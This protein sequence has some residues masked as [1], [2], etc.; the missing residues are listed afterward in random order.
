MTLTFPI[1]SGKLTMSVEVS[2]LVESVRTDFQQID[3][4]DSEVFGRML[5]LDG[6]I[7][8][9]TFDER[10]Y[11][12]ALVWAP[13]S[14]V[15]D[16]RSALVVGGGD[17]GVLRELCR[18]RSIERIDMVEIDQGVI[19]VCRR[20][21]P[22]LSDGAFD[23]PRVHLTVGDAFAFVKSADGPYDLI[24]VDCTDVYE[25]EEGELSEMLFTE[26]F[27][28]DV[29]RLLAPGGF[30]VTQADNMVFCP[31]SLDEIERLFS[32]VFPS[33]G[34][35]WATVPSFGG[36]SAFCWGSH[37]PKPAEQAP[38]GLPDLHYLTADIY[39]ATQKPLVLSA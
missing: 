24:V 39:A 35:Y 34:S 15:A 10:A 6:H 2:A 29:K 23:D 3:V 1:R 17:G 30:V 19:D 5:L 28:Q 8:L 4:Y 7:Q 32:G 37:G 33:V 11:H 13:L 38:S 16:P 21:M 9:T 18:H 22:S 14:N 20:T 27:Y 26:D 12:E 25:E 36:F 31:Y